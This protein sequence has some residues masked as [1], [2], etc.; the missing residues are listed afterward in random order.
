MTTPAHAGRMLF[1]N[2]P[3]ADLDRSKAFF[4]RLGFSYNPMF[5]DETAACML[6]G[7]QASVMLR[8]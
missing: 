2:I 1:V 5:T 7:E 4:A 6:V 3:V 8:A